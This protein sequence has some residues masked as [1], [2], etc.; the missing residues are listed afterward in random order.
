MPLNAP[1]KHKYSKSILVQF[2]KIQFNIIL[3]YS[4]RPSAV[5][6]ILCFQKLPDDGTL[7]P[8]H[9][10]VVTQYE[11]GF[12]MFYYILI[13]AW[14]C[15]TYEI[16]KPLFIWDWNADLS[17]SFW[18]IWNLSP[19]CRWCCFFSMFAKPISLSNHGP[20]ESSAHI[21]NTSLYN[22]LQD[23]LFL[24]LCWKILNSHLKFENLKRPE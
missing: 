22:F 10:A 24:L 3:P 7:V 8:K 14:S 21:H 19:G 18:N 2:L 15:L 9:V 11:V 6:M 1:P 13:I 12:M 16:N 23:Y 20:D 4:Y 5:H 17:V